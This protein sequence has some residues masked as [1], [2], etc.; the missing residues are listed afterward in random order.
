MKNGVLGDEEARSYL[1]GVDGPSPAT[2]T[3][4]EQ[5]DDDQELEPVGTSPNGTDPIGD[6]S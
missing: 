6:I 5:D 3:E 4:D 1:P 2:A